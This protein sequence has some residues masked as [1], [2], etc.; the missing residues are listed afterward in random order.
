[1]QVRDI[2]T[3]KPVCATPSTS[4]VE[5]ACMMVEQDCGEIPVCDSSKKPIG[6][7]TDRDIACRLVAKGKDPT[8]ATAE[9]CMSTP[10][11]TVRPSPN[12]S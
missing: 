9:D 3:D 12:S 6:V 1:M 2:M 7:V 10:V 8:K 11:V 5:V 4:L